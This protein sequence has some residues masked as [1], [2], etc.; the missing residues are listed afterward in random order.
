MA[1]T[2][3]FSGELMDRGLG[4]SQSLLQLSK[5]I[6]LSMMIA[7]RLIILLI[8]FGGMILM[9]LGLIGEYVGRNFIAINGQPQF[10]IEKIIGERKNKN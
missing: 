9:S 3:V 4:V 7:D 5:I 10:V 2:N 1:S 6:T 8:F